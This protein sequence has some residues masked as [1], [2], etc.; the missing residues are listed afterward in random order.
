METLHANVQQSVNLHKM[1]VNLKIQA[2]FWH[3]LMVSCVV[4]VTEGI[5]GVIHYAVDLKFVV[6]VDDVMTFE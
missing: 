1:Y 4:T 5:I 2:S 3:I 6:V